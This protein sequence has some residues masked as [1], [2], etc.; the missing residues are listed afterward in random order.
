MARKSGSI[1]E[2]TRKQILASA[3]EEFA[4]YGFQ[5]SSLRRICAGAGVTTGA[6]YAYFK[7]K[8]DLFANVISPA[9]GYILNLMKDHYEKELAATSENCLSEEDEDFLAMQ[10]ILDFY[11]GNKALCQIVLQNQE[12]PA[13]CAFFDELMERMDQQ[14]VFLFQQIHG[15]QTADTLPVLD[16]VTVHWLSHLQVDAIFH[17]ISHDME[18]A[19]AERQLKQMVQFLRAGFLSLFQIEKLK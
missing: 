10:K 19:C 11:Y 15:S 7:D 2:E 6:L 13:V 18:P 14:T 5:N 4:K 16:P 9:T 1:P 8:D 3:A 17:V 12:H